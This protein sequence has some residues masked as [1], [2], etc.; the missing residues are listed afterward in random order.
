LENKYRKRLH[1]EVRSLISGIRELETSIS[2]LGLASTLPG[3]AGVL[4]KHLSGPVSLSVSCKS[5]AI[6]HNPQKF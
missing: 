3:E 4:E 5:G 2:G 6:T 1:R